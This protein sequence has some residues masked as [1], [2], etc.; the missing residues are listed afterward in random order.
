MQNPSAC[1]DNQVE[2]LQFHTLK[3]KQYTVCPRARAACTRSSKWAGAEACGNS[4]TEPKV[5]QQPFAN[6][7]VGCA[8]NDSNTST[9]RVNI[10]SVV[11][12]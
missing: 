1:N 10:K 3:A 7:R 12:R 8:I 6:T 9:A 11:A 5:N 2:Y 4:S